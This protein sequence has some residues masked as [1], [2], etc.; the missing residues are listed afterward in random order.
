[1]LEQV[2][3]HHKTMDNVRYLKLSV[4]IGYDS[5]I[6]ADIMLRSSINELCLIDTILESIKDNIC[7]CRKGTRLMITCRIGNDSYVVVRNVCKSSDIYYSIEKIIK[8]LSII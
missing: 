7:Y 1:M 4:K 5:E 6:F 8:D 2:C 3:E